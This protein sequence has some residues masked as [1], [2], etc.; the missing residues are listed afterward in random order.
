VKTGIYTKGSQYTHEPEIFLGI[1]A[2]KFHDRVTKCAN[3]AIDAVG[4]A[5]G[6]AKQFASKR[7]YVTA[8]P[9]ALGVG[10]GMYG[11]LMAFEPEPKSV[12]VEAKRRKGNLFY[13]MLKYNKQF[14]R[15]VDDILNGT[16]DDKVN[17][18]T[19]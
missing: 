19:K 3:D 5:Y 8:L 13:Y 7:W 4:R 12:Q 1:D 11:L 18:D 15:K 6:S 10:I 16:L 17:S 9:M 14:Q 2:E